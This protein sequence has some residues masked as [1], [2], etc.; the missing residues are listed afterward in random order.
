MIRIAHLIGILCLLSVAA[1]HAV[2]ATPK[3]SEPIVT[4][5]VQDSDRL[6]RA[7]ATITSTHTVC[8][9]D[10]CGAIHLDPDHLFDI[11]VMGTEPTAP[12]VILFAGDEN[13]RHMRRTYGFKYL[14]ATRS[15]SGCY[16][17]E[18]VSADGLITP[19]QTATISGAMLD[20]MAQSLI[21][22]LEKIAR[23]SIEQ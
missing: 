17:D 22:M 18:L 20:T 16:V 13:E 8:T 19:K 23:M 5:R 9:D 6:M 3:L 11:T 15:F 10:G 7:I 2:P 4:L 1:A 14:P 12:I 21:T